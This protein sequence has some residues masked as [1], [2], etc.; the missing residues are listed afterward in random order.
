MLIL[1][2]VLLIEYKILV[3]KVMGFLIGF[4]VDKL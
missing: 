3:I 1:I 2:I 4:G